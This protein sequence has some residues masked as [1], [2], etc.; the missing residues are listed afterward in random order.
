MKWQASVILPTETL[1]DSYLYQ[2]LLL[3][4][5]KKRL[6]HVSTP[7]LHTLRSVAG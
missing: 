1:A 4:I 7:G 2:F 5:R 3:Q 6:P